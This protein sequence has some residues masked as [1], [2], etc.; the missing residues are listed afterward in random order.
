MKSWTLV[1]AA[2]A[3]LVGVGQLNGSIVNGSF[4]TGDTTG[5]TEVKPYGA[6]TT[7]VTSHNEQPYGDPYGKMTYSPTDGTYFALLKTDGGGAK[8]KLYQ[9]FTAETGYQ[10]SF[11]VFFDTEDYILSGQ[12]WNDSGRAYLTNSSG[13]AQI[14]PDLFYSDVLTV[15]D[16]GETPWTS[17]TRTI[18]T[19][20]TFR[21]YFEVENYLDSQVDS[22]LGID[23]V[24]VVPEPGSVV[25]W[26]LLLAVLAITA[27][28]WRW[29]R[30]ET[31]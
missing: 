11:D 15:G 2:V 18:T 14:G 3:V 5:W 24:E 28:R 7:V 9:S 1:L 21:L 6:T 29:R 16:Y 19:A 22:Y 31:A 27:G 26:S 23:A 12:A 10:I 17:V 20:G 13:T 8:N 25:V 30:R 4:E